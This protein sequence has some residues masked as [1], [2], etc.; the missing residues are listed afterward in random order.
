M[1]QHIFTQ[2]R[3]DKVGKIFHIS[4]STIFLQASR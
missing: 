1:I 2:D 3:K 4:Y